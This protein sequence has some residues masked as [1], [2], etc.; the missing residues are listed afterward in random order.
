MRNVTYLY[1]AFADGKDVPGFEA[2]VKM[3]RFVGGVESRADRGMQLQ[4]AGHSQL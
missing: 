3:Q 1:E 2:A 4:V